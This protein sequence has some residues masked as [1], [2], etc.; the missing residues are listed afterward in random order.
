MHS[1]AGKGAAVGAVAGIVTGGLVAAFT[2]TPCSGWACLMHP[3][4]GTATVLGAVAGLLG[5]VAIG[6][7]VGAADRGEWEPVRTAG[8][9]VTVAPR[10]VGV[11]LA[12]R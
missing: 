6:T 5:G 8:L 1:H 9:Q 7:I 12:F 11:S 3:D 2:W 10:A 4:M